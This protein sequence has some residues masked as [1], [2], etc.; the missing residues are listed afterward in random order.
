MPRRSRI[1]LDGVPLHIVQRGH[2]R[3]PCFFA[4]DDYASYLFWLGRAL[5]EADCPL[6]AYVLMTNRWSSYR[7]N[8]LAGLDTLVT[9]HA[10]YLRLACDDAERR[11]T[12]RALFRTH[13]DAPAIDD[14]RLALH[15]GQPL[16]NSRFLA[17]IEAMTGVRREAKP[18]GRPR[19]DAAET[20]S[21]ASNDQR[22]LGLN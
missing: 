19:K 13:L 4:D 8:A 7:A 10:L 22:D 15:Q 18:R 20:A 1:H 9:H 6:H 2:N 12:Y 16:G 11:A 5:R 3:E 17:R 21:S 14:I